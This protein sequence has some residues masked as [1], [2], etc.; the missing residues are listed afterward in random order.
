MRSNLCKT[1][2]EGVKA[3]ANLTARFSCTSTRRTNSEEVD[4]HLQTFRPW[5][6][7]EIEKCSAYVRDV[8]DGGH[9]TFIKKDIAERLHLTVI[10]KTKI[11][12]N[13]FSTSMAIE[14][15]AASFTYDCVVNMTTQT[16]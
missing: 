14:V 4:G 16:M 6:V 8:R 13:A 10:R 5:I 15:T 7:T 11:L 9:R 1:E 12:M 2:T 3:E